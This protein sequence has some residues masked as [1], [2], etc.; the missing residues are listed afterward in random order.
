MNMVGHPH[1]VEKALAAGVDMICA[2]VGQLGL[3]LGLGT[4]FVMGQGQGPGSI[5]A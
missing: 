5:G 1:H 3:G 2:Q 4:Q